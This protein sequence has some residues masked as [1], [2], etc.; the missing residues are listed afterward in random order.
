MKKWLI[1]A[2]AVLLAA[3]GIGYVALD[4]DQR[5]VVANL[6]TDRNVLFWPE[7]TRNAAFRA[8]DRFPALAQARVIESGDS[9]YPLPDGKALDLGSFDLDGFMQEQNGAAIVVVLDGEVVLERYGLGFDRNGKWTSFSVAKSLTSTLVGAALNDG[10]IASL[11]DPVSRYIPQMRGSAYDDVTI[12]QLLTMSS[13]VRWSEDYS[14]PESDVAR[15][16]EHVPDEGVDATVSYMRQLPRAHEPGTT[17]RY[18]TGETN[19]IGV[20]VSEATGKPLAEYLSEKVWAPFGMEQDATWLLGRSDAEIGGCCIQATT[21]DMARFG[22]FVLGDGMAGGER[23]V[24]EG[25]FAAATDPAFDTGR[26]GRGYGYQ[27]W[28]YAGGAYAASGL[29]GQGIFIDPARELVIATNSNWP[30]SNGN[31]GE[32]DRRNAFYETVQAAV[33]ARN[34]AI[35]DGESEG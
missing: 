22:L 11:E 6:P 29:F 12:R 23:K 33:D 8:M 2:A 1:G 7:E 25:W 9:V 15:F 18:N 10:D 35:G 31:G 27:W 19:L 16:N 20:L 13:G 34:A 4:D 3:C 14:D 21:R 30:H 5:A 17:W 32:G 28:T 24:P 26:F